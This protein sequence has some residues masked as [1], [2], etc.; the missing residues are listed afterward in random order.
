[1]LT[2]VTWIYQAGLVRCQNKLFSFPPGPE[3]Q[4]DPSV[5]QDTCP[6]PCASARAP[7][8]SAITL[9]PQRKTN[10]LGAIYLIILQS[11]ALLNS[12]HPGLHFE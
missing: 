8:N 2:T 10:S 7:I 5:S 11:T 3:L 1:M 6:L 12:V 4:T 9:E